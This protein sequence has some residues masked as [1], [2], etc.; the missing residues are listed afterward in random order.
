[1]RQIANLLRG[2][3]PSEVRILS[4]PPKELD[5]GVWCNGS[6]KDFDSFGLDSN[7]GTPANSGL[8]HG[9][10]PFNYSRS[11]RERLRQSTFEYGA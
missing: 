8:T 6:T 2:G 9:F 10:T 3:S 11:N 4:L 1:M 7:S 5:I